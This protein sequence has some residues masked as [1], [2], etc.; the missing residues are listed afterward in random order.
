MRIAEVGMLN[1]EIIGRR[2]KV[3]KVEGDSF[4][5]PSVFNLNS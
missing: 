4:L 2:W 3:L 1:K 5:L